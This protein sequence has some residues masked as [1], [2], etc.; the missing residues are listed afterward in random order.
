QGNLLKGRLDKGALPGTALGE[1]LGI[2]VL[3]GLQH[4]VRVDRQRRD[5]V[6]DLGQLVTGLEVAKPQRVLYLLHELQVGRHPRGRVKPKLNR[7][8]PFIYSHK[9]RVQR[10]TP[11]STPN[12]QPRRGPAVETTRVTGKAIVGN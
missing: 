11:E 6:P 4:R 1:A 12:G 7:T 3:V 10:T 5:H 9:T 8:V 2:Q